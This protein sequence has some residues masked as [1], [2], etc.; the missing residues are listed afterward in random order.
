MLYHPSH[1]AWNETESWVILKNHDTAALFNIRSTKT[2]VCLTHLGVLLPYQW[3]S[4]HF[5]DGQT[6][7]WNS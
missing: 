6:E 7:A 2:L 4:F 5:T 3:L 1:P